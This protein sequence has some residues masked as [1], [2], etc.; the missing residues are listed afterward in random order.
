MKIKRS[1]FTNRFFLTFGAIALLTL[2][3]NVY[4]EFNDDGII[5]G[6]VVNTAGE[7]VAGASVVLSDR[8]LLVS[9][10]VDETV[11]TQDGSFKFT[12]HRTHRLYLEARKEGIGQ[13]RQREFRLYFQGQNLR[14]DEPM[15][16]REEDT[17]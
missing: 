15:L 16:L 14:L 5:E 12:G 8:S 1:F 9:T 2:V 13:F 10:P 3:W 6:R 4:I 11:T 7:A 17:T